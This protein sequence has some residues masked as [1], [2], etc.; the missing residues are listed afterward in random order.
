MVEIG[1]AVDPEYRRRGY[2]RAALEALLQRAAREPQL[3]TVRMT[4]SPDNVASYQLA[5]Q[6]RFADVGQQWAY[7]DSLEIIYEVDAQHL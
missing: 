4:I 6:Y 7:E 1:Y 3:R 5:S 2:A